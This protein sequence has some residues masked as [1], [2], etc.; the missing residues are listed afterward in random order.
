[1]ATDVVRAIIVVDK[2]KIVAVSVELNSD[3]LISVPWLEVTKI[4]TLADIRAAEK[5]GGGQ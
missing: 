3:T 1:M 2:G 4:G 5:K